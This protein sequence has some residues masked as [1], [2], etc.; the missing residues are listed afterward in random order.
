[1]KVTLFGTTVFLHPATNLLVDVSMIALQLSRESYIS[2]LLLTEIKDKL[3]QHPN[4]LPPIVLTL[5]GIVTEDRPTQHIKASSPML[6]TL[7]GIITD[8]KPVHHA[9]APMPMEVT[10]LPIIIDVKPS[11]PLKA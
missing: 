7:L 4:A 10:P 1:M 3:S 6:V 2:L 9:K 11:H 8:F 5:Y